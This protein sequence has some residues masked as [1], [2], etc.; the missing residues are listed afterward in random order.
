M[1][2]RIAALYRFGASELV[3]SELRNV[4]HCAG[5]SLVHPQHGYI[6]VLDA[7]G[8]QV[9]STEAALFQLLHE[10]GEVSFQWW[11]DAMPSVY[12]R[13]RAIGDVIVV[14][15]GL[16]GLTS[17]E[18]SLIGEALLEYVRSEREHV[19]AFVYDPEGVTEDCDM[20]AHFVR[21]EILDWR[22]PDVGFPDVLV[23]RES[24]QFRL[25]NAP[26]NVERVSVDGLVVMKWRQPG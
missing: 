3:V 2:H 12:C 6:F 15:F 10:Q 18:R 7:E 23:V 22:R 14:E 9:L 25:K 8:D 5:A 24:V 19:V 11:L 26:S 16:E 4:L 1:S 21:G 17:R 13:V 20:D